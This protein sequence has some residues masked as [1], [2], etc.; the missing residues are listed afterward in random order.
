MKPITNRS[1]LAAILFVFTLSILACQ[2]ENSGTAPQDEEFYS[3]TSTE[4]DAES[5]LVFSD[6]FDNV[7]GVNDFVGIAYVGIFGRTG[8]TSGGSGGTDWRSDTIRCFTVTTTHLST[9]NSFP[10]TIVIDFGAGCVGRDGHNRSGKI[11]T[12][13]T[14]RLLVPGAKATTTFE[15]FYIDSI[16]VEG[17]HEISNI[18]TITELKLQVVVENAKLTKPN[19]NY[20]EWNSRKTITRLEGNLTPLPLDDV[21]S[22]DG[23]AHGKVKRGN[24]IVAWNTEIVEPL[25]KKFSCRWIVKGRLRV[26]RLNLSNTSPWIAILDYGN[27]NCDNRAVLTI[28]GVSHEIT[29]P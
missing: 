4:A 26:A 27:G 14:N 18:G 12:T 8:N 13:Y 2:R 11:I 29:L 16:H 5:E 22:I 15:N 21:F 10:V 17:T 24:I 25:I 28:N 9:T 23:E 7:I 6:V 20:T 19:G 3:Q 1:R